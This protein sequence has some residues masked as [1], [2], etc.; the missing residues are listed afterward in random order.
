MAR[1]ELLAR[2]PVVV[3]GIP[4]VLALAALGGWPLGL[5]I[6]AVAAI[7]AY[8]FFALA[9]VGG[10]L[11]FRVLGVA[12]TVFLV[13]WATVWPRF[14]AFAPGALAAVLTLA[15]ACLALAVWRRWPDGK[16]ISAVS[17]TVTGAVYVG[18]ALAF[19]PLLRHLPLADGSQPE[20][21]H[22]TALLFFPLA[23]T[24]VGDSCAYLGG[25]AWGRTK[26]IPQVSPGKTVAGSVASFVGSMAVAALYVAVALPDQRPGLTPVTGAL[27]G[28]ALSAAAQVGDLVASVAKRE[29]GVKDSGTLFPGHGGALDRL[30]ALLFTVPLTYALVLVLGALS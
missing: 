20:A 9:A 17:A 7:G 24:W 10:G 30:D 29:A 18:G 2:L 12:G 8:E 27:V 16:P 6:A 19:A 13:L 21:F 23:V 5:L 22:G 11:P 3:L 28:L 4:A 26:L 15:L 14:N 25:R 1:S